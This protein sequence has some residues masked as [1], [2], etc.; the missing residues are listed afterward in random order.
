MSFVSASDFGT[1][2][3]STVT[4]ANLPNLNPGEAQVLSITL[5]MDDVSLDSYR[6]YA[7]ISEDS[8]ED[9][10]ITDEDS[11]PD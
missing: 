11:T 7:E 1:N 2:G 8:A 6:N 3:G 10:G 4:W 9:Y 5:R